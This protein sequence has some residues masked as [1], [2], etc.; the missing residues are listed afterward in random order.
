M[1]YLVEDRVAHTLRPGL[2]DE[3]KSE[4]LSQD[5]QV[6]QSKDLEGSLRHREKILFD[7]GRIITG[8][9]PIWTRDQDEK[10]TGFLHRSKVNGDAASQKMI[11]RDARYLKK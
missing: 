2:A 5:G 11:R 4:R 7:L 8:I 6:A 3:G 1:K 9:R 10:R